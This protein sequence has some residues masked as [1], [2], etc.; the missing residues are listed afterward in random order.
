MTTTYVRTGRHAARLRSRLNV[1]SRAELEAQAT[2]LLDQ[3]SAIS[4]V[5]RTIAGSPNDLQPVFDTIVA[6]GARLCRSERATLRMVD[7]EGLLLVSVKLPPER[8]AGHSPPP[9]RVDHNSNV[10]RLAAR[11]S[12]VHIPNVGEHEFFRAG[13]PA[14]LSWYKGGLRTLILVPM[15]DDDET[16]GLISFGRSRIEPFTEE[17]IDLITDFAAQAAIAL[18]ITR[19]ERDLRESEAK[20]RAAINGIAGLVAIM[21]PSGELESVNRPIVEYF[22]RTVEELKNWGKSDAVHPEDLPR[23][24]ESYKV[25]LAT[26][27][28]F[29]QELRLRRFDGE[30][31]WFENRGAPIRDESGHVAR[32]YCLLVDIDNR[33]RA[34]ERLRV[35]HTVAQI[36]AE[37]ATIEEATPRI[38]LAIGECLGWDVG[39]L[40]RVERD[41]EVLRCVELWHTASI[42]VPEFDRV[43][44]ESTFVPGLGLPGRVWSSLEPEYIPDV[45][46][47]ENFPR[48][49]IAEL[50]G[51][52]AAF[53]FPILLGGQAS[54]VVE[55][56]SREIRQPDQELLNV[57]ATIG[58]QIG[59]FIERKRAEGALRGSERKHRGLIESVP[60]HFW[61]AN[62]DGK[63][64]YVNQRLLDYFGIRRR[65]DQRTSDLSADI[66]GTVHPDDVPETERAVSHAFQTGESFQRVHRLRRA[67]GEY[68][69]HRVRAEP[70][71][72]HE[73]DI[74]QWYGFSIDIDEA[75]KAED[76]LRRSEA[77]LTQAQRLS[78]IGTWV[79]N[80]TTRRFLYWSDESYRIW[81]FDPLQGLPSRDDL[82]GRIHPDDR[83][84]VWEEVQEALREQRDFLAEFRILLPDGTVKYLEANT[85]H[86][87]SPLGAL[88]EV[89]CTSIDVTERKRAQEDHEKLRQLESDLAHMNRVGMIGELAASL[90]HEI[91]QPIASARN[92]ARAAQNFL[93]KQTPDLTEVDEALGCVVAD[94][95]R[96]GNIVDRIRDHVRKA[97]PRKA[98]WD[99]NAA[100][101]EVVV[102][103]RSVIVQNGASVQTRLAE[104]LSHVHGDRVQL[105]Q[106]VLNLILNAVEAMGSVET[107][108]RE[109]LIITEQGSTG[110]LVAV[111][112]SGPGIDAEN[113]ERV[114]EAFYTTKS[115]G[116]G[117]GLSIC[118]SIIDAHGGRLWA[119]ANEPRGAVFQFTLPSA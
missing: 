83:E 118:R 7:K 38:L 1:L 12:T 81:G 90:S 71:R 88:L 105:Q 15:V 99:L 64:T 55:F 96:A 6:S 78:R 76:A 16:I 77:W 67:D 79:M 11:K 54:G 60:C 68:R 48:A 85:H 9:L 57:L 23:I 94:A 97:P 101:N 19:R 92:N 30:Y 91:T 8:P 32:W 2:E 45:V 75:K 42:E 3:Q 51:L 22:G 87:F 49:P 114:F 107:G 89:I 82:W 50:E 18:G 110:A 36:L 13:D 66:R 73:G 28:P 53:G 115:S 84:W 14:T 112:D 117:M 69:W 98:L 21:A 74:I 106:V 20:F 65:E 27:T 35:Q 116:T 10:G 26:D 62:P 34:E 37:A 24:L 100:I 70:L 63:P 119:E 111:R 47:D 109:L 44:R 46:S 103:A 29:H 102:L 104:G 4:E 39:V 86:E 40:W 80:G 31:R 5:L 43:S 58:S 33:K 56:F 93:H 108:T 25:S 52:R 59:Q 95:D 113:I 17:E 61:S 41:G 72:D